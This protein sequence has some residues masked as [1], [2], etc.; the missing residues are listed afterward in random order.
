METNQTF[1]VT[2]WTILIGAMVHVLQDRR[3][4]R[5]GVVETVSTDGRVIWLEQG[6]GFGRQV[7]DKG[8]GFQILISEQQLRSIGKL[9]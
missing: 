7:V 9:H 8:S 2:D 1:L 6:H 3:I 4:L 5:M